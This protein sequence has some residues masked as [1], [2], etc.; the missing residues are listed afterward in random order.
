[1]GIRTMCTS[2]T[3]DTAVASAALTKHAGMFCGAPGSS[4]LT[5]I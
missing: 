2:A 1:M 5:Q 3:Q 4:G